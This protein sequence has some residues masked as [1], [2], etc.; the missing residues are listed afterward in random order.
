MGRCTLSRYLV[1]RAAEHLVKVWEPRVSFSV[2]LRHFLPLLLEFLPEINI[3]LNSHIHTTTQKDRW[4]Q[5]HDTQ[6]HVYVCKCAARLT[7]TAALA[8]W[9]SGPYAANS[10]TQ[11]SADSAET[12]RAQRHARLLTASITH[13]RACKSLNNTQLKAKKD[14]VLWWMRVGERKKG[15]NGR[16]TEEEEKNLT[17]IHPS[18]L[19]SLY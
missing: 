2:P 4:M 19:S 16:Q 6:V 11:D 18:F 9:K 7:S 17:L 15:C 10:S 3:T 5:G 8:C 13:H 12:Y 1:I 14:N